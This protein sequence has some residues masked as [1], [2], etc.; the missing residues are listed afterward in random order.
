M[1]RSFLSSPATSQAFGGLLGGPAA[2]LDGG[3][4]FRDCCPRGW[5][6][7]A[8]SFSVSNEQLSSLP[9]AAQLGTSSPLGAAAFRAWPFSPALMAKNIL[10]R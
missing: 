6:V 7:L 8:L 9:I 3:D 10:S 2:A 4:Y 1:K 5:A